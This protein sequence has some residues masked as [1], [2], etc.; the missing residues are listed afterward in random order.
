MASTGGNDAH[1]SSSKPR[2]SSGQSGHHTRSESSAHP[3]SSE[4]KYSRKISLRLIQL[5]ASRKPPSAISVDARDLDR[6][7]RPEL[8]LGVQ[9]LDLGL[10]PDLQLRQSARPRPHRHPLESRAFDTDVQHVRIGGQEGGWETDQLR[11][12]AVARD[13]L[14][15][16]AAAEDPPSVQVDFQVAA[17]PF[18]IKREQV[19]VL[20]R[21]GGRERGTVPD[22]AAE[23]G[24]GD[25]PVI[26][27]RDRG[28]RLAVYCLPNVAG[29]D[30]RRPNGQHGR[31]RRPGRKQR[32]E[33]EEAEEGTGSHR[34]ALCRMAFRIRG[35]ARGGAG[36]AATIRTR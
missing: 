5:S 28:Q 4:P 15:H 7:D 19:V 14:V 20:Q 30:H 18:D 17:R 35:A 21:G 12:V 16:A 27:Q 9:R 8:P 11:P 29:R 10:R 34:R 3:I 32:P 13:R 26:R 2:V 1:T 36:I 33:G 24:P 23:A 25:R 22:T 6:R 31:E